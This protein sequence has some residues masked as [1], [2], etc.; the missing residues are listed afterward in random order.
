MIT[1]FKGKTPQSF[2]LMYKCYSTSFLVKALS[3]LVEGKNF[4]IITTV[5]KK[6]SDN[7]L[8]DQRLKTLPLRLVT[9]YS[10][11]LCTVSF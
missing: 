4:I 3:K 7:I 2:H 9:R 6:H 5:C 10:L 1:E 8:T 11:L